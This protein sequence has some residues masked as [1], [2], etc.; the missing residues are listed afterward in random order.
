MDC[1]QYIFQNGRDFFAT[2][3]ERNDRIIDDPWAMKENIS[4]YDLIPP[5]KDRKAIIFN[6]LTEALAGI[7]TSLN[8]YILGLTTA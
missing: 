1:V 6:S 3:S 4:Y 8:Y 5:I 2:T 7:S